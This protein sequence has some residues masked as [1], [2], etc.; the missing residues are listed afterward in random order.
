MRPC[1][2]GLDVRHLHGRAEAATMAVARTG[3]TGRRAGTSNRCR[4]ADDVAVAAAQPI[5][6]CSTCLDQEHHRESDQC[7]CA[8][9]PRRG[10]SQS[11]AKLTAAAPFYL[12]QCLVPSKF[13]KFYKILRHIKFLDICMEH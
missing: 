12:W 11:V 4:R 10:R 6:V 2:G 5:D 3:I 9:S 1:H 7:G 8:Q 13:Q